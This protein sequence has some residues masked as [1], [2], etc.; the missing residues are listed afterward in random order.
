V[1]VQ[2]LSGTQ[3]IPSGC[4]NDALSQVA[5]SNYLTSYTKLNYGVK[6]H[7]RP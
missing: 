1:L 5:W 3:K 7:N 4:V 2:F 6:S